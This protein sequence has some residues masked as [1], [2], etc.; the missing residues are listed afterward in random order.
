MEAELKSSFP[1]LKVELI[2]GDGGVFDVRYDGE[3]I[4]SKKKTKE[5]RFPGDGEIARLV[6]DRLP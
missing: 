1:G 3:M 6:K 4:F 5:D 2:E